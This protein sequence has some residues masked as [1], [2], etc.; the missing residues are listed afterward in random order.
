MP[1][2]HEALKKGVK[3]PSFARIIKVD[4]SRF[5]RYSALHGIVLRLL[6]WPEEVPSLTEAEVVFLRTY[7]TM[8]SNGCRPSNHRLRAE[9]K[10]GKPALI[11]H[12][13]DL[14]LKMVIQIAETSRTNNW[15][16]IILHPKL[17]HLLGVRKPAAPPYMISW[18][19]T[20]VSE[21][22]LA[23]YRVVWGWFNTFNYWPEPRDIAPAFGV[24]R[25]AI[26]QR[27]IELDAIKVIRYVSYRS[28]E[29]R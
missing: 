13:V 2:R 23:V 14:H 29:T 17:W 1:I 11:K 18:V 21:T 22:T 26:R 10:I 15:S 4:A 27:L 6:P 19:M 25:E 5:V 3:R 12:I 16:H 20:K 28:H 8:L 7:M 24:S 9:L